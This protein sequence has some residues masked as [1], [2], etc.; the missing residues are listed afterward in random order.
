MCPFREQG[1]GPMYVTVPRI[2][3]LPLAAR[4]GAAGLSLASEA[5]QP[6]ST[7]PQSSSPICNLKFEIDSDNT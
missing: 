7:L 5:S 2:T 1:R 3:P 6:T 4:G